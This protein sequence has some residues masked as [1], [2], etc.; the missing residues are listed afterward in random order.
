[1]EDGRIEF[2]GALPVNTH[3]GNHS[4]AYIHGLPH[5]IESVRQFR[6]DVDGPDPATPS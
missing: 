6:G 2:D 3:G 5:I 1:M 4:E